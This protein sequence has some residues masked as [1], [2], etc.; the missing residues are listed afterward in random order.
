MLERLCFGCLSGFSVCWQ[1]WYRILYCI[2]S[3]I[4]EV[5]VRV[6]VKNIDGY[7]TIQCNEFLLKS[8]HFSDQEVLR[9]RN[10]KI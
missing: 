10:P 6:S 2:S 3:E 4:I 9:L 8:C 7:N 5:K 1:I